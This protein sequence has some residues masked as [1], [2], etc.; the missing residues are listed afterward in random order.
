MGSTLPWRTGLVVLPRKANTLM[1]MDYRN[2]GLRLSKSAF[3]V[4][5]E[6]VLSQSLQNSTPMQTDA[7]LLQKMLQATVATP[8]EKTLPSSALCRSIATCL[9]RD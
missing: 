2:D 5:D 7:V 8:A 4:M 1:D 3:L 6:V 9:F